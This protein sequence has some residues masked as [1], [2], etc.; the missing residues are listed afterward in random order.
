MFRFNDTI[1]N[2][3]RIAKEDASEDEINN[4]LKMS[5]C[6]FVYDLPNGIHTVVGEGGST[7]SGGELQRLS[8]ARA[9]LK[10]SKIVILDEATANID[11]E[12]EEKLIKAIDSLTNNKTVIMIA[13][14]LKTVRNCDNIYV[15]DKGKIIESGKHEELMKNNGVYNKFV[16]DRKEAVRWKI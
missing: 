1:I 11:P 10:D 2:N 5:C 8:I 12:N 9:I 7:L 13:H 14:R 3:L 6:E 16:S 4:A 15:I